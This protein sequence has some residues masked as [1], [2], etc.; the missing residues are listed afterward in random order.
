MNIASIDIGTNTVLMLLAKADSS[1][2]EIFPIKNF[3]EMPRLGKNLLQGKPISEDKIQDLIGI[4]KNF[5]SEIDKT[6]CE[7]IIA[8]ATN[9]FRIAS[10]SQEIINRVEKETGIKINVIPGEEEAKYSY[11]GAIG[12]KNEEKFLVID[13]GGGSTE[14][15]SGTK[16]N[17][18][19]KKSFFTGAVS[20]TEKFFENDPPLQSEI[21]NAKNFIL[22]IFSDLQSEDFTG[23]EAIAVA[24]TPTS[25]SC[26]KQN[27]K[28][29]SD[30]AV[31]NSNLTQK[32]LKNLIE[33]FVEN[34]SK[35]LYDNFPGVLKGREDI[36]LAGTLILLDLMRIL[37]IEE[38]TVST[39]GI[40]YG[41]IY[42]FLIS[43]F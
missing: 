18:I 15:V 34:P 14:I 23:S 36:I 37:K 41:A 30:D 33:Y 1:T 28:F 17:I 32:D 13:I 11:F 4:M 29:Y 20:L 6:G 26:I 5:R 10:N 40:R 27:I 35:K 21:S 3:Y 9:A 2:N 12:S 39:K 8:T 31:E 42:N 16:E 7:K 24:G 19:Y 22:E 38:L 25:L 43:D